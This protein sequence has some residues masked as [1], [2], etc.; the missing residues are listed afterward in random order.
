MFIRQRPSCFGGFPRW[1]LSGV[2]W[3]VVSGL[4]GR[5]VV[6]KGVPGRVVKRRN[7]NFPHDTWQDVGNSSRPL[8][9]QYQD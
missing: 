6:W 5:G 7:M 4:R 3:C 9:K 1:W 8:V 2:V